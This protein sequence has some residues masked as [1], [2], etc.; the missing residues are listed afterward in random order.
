M[1]QTPNLTSNDSSSHE[2]ILAAEEA[3][4]LLELTFGPQQHALLKNKEPVV[5]LTSGGTS[6]PL[7]KNAVRWLTNFSTG[8]RGAALAE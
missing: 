8:N 4:K 2:S 1:S 6:V 3:L 7:E 5:L